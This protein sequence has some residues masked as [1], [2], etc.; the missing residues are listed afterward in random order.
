MEMKEFLNIMSKENGNIIDIF[1]LAR[2]YYLATERVRDFALSNDT[3]WSDEIL[4]LLDL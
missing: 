3:F 1:D 2:K 4:R